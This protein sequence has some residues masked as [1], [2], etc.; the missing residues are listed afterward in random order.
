MDNDQGSVT[1]QIRSKDGVF[2]RLVRRCVLRG[3][4]EKMKM[5]ERKRD[6]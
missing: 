5:R 6:G 4:A 2:E 1:L 3:E